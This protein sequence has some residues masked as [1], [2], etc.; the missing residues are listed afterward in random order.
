M[1]SGPSRA[2][3]ASLAGRT[4]SSRPLPDSAKNAP[5]DPPTAGHSSA[6]RSPEASAMRSPAML[7]P[8]PLLTSVVIHKSL[9]SSSRRKPG[10]T[11]PHR[12]GGGMDPGFRRDDERDAPASTDSA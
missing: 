2:A 5:S 12:A 3:L 9:P 1:A 6:L 8:F 10:S 4:K 7:I 11:L